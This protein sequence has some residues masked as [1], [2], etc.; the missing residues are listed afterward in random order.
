MRFSPARRLAIPFAGSVLLGAAA[1]GTAGRPEAVPEAGPAREAPPGEG[2][3]CSLGIYNAIAE[4]GRRCFAGRDPEFQ[5]EL[6]RAVA[7]ID[8]YVLAN[9]EWTAD[10]LARFKRDQSRVG[11]P[12]ATVCTDEMKGYYSYSAS[13][14]AEEIR[15]ATDRLLERPGPPTWGD[16]L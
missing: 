2:V 7:R 13:R 11:E 3:I 16:C 6:G 15:T 10:D 9:S 12:E 8:E 5:A 14:G 4:V 1:C